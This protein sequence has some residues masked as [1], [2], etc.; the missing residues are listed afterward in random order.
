[1]MPKLHNAAAPLSPRLVALQSPRG[2]TCLHGVARGRSRRRKRRW[3]TPRPG[4]WCCRPR[5]GQR[6]V[7]GP[8]RRC[9]GCLP[10]P[11]PGSAAALCSVPALLGARP[12]GGGSTHPAHLL[13]C[14]SGRAAHG[15]GECSPG[16]RCFGGLSAAAHRRPLWLAA[17]SG[18]QPTHRAAVVSLHCAQHPVTPAPTPHTPPP[19]HPI[20]CS[21]R[22]VTC[23]PSQAL[24]RR[25]GTAARRARR[26]PALL[27][28]SG[29]R[30]RACTCRTPS[31][32]R[33]WVCGCVVP[34]HSCG[35]DA[36]PRVG[37]WTLQGARLSAG[38]GWRLRAAGV[39]AGLG[40]GPGAPAGAIVV[41]GVVA[42]ELTSL[43]PAQL[44]GARASRGLAAALRLA[45]AA[46]P[47]RS[48]EGAVR[49]A[50]AWAH[51]GTGDAAVSV[52]ALRAPAASA[53]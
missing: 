5:C 10:T 53:A 14:Q 11:Q 7:A 1:M 42:S 32:V 41:D 8:A 40:A 25:A 3:V 24:W 34:G 26:W 31:Q 47:A 20:L 19:P 36:Q 15:F 43:V 33:L 23:C 49:L 51:G 22:L 2:I 18:L 44:A 12:R 6:C 28:L 17:L 50:S 48:V 37:L 35:N 45:F 4:H 52:A 39:S 9:R 16:A 30:R 27:P 13:S 46:L 38:P 29:F 21:W